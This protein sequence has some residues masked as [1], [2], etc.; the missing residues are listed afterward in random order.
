MSYLMD[1]INITNGQD[2]IN[3]KEVEPRPL[4]H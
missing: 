2:C 3:D 1:L 4:C